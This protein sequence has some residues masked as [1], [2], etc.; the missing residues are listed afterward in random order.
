M[1][2]WL[3]LLYG[4]GG[5]LVG[6]GVTWGTMSTRVTRA[7]ADISSLQHEQSGLAAISERLARIEAILESQHAP[8]RRPRAR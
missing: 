7:E 2:D 3:S 8:K 4:L 6:A 5:S 1:T